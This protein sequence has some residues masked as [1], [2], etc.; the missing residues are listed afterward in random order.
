MAIDRMDWHYGGDYPE[1][2]PTENGGTHI[3]FYLTWIIQNNLV[4]EFHLEESEDEVELVKARKMDG[5]E[6]LISMCDEKFIS[7]DL[8][9]EGNAFTEFYYGAEE[10]GYFDDYERV[11]QSDLPSTYHVENSW[12]NYDKIAVIISDAFAKWKKAR[13]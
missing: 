2:L 10:G 12:E 11:L 3:G 9:D 7:E 5:R 8:N 13:A 1:G 4:G 6:F